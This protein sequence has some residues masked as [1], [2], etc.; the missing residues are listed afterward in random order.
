[1]P[2]TDPGQN[3]GMTIRLHSLIT[4]WCLA[5]V[6]SCAWAQTTG[7]TTPTTATKPPSSSAKPASASA[8]AKP[9]AHGNNGA[10]AAAASAP[11]LVIK[12]AASA[13]VQ[14]KRQTRPLTSAEKL[15]SVAPP[16]ELRPERTIK[17]QVTIPLSKTPPDSTHSKGRAA[18]SSVND[19]AGRCAAIA[20]ENQRALCR[21]QAGL[22][23]PKR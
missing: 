3:D 2:G 21:E 17:P 19:S 22:G 1:V 4:A 20:D 11:A 12:P 8:P 13:P 10:K 23:Q 9:A 7:T 5:A 6:A 14:P 18:G 16:G 15:E